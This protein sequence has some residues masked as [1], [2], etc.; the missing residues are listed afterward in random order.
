LESD[1]PFVAKIGALILGALI[2]FIKPLFV[3]VISYICNKYV[4][5]KQNHMRKL[6]AFLIGL[7]LM[8]FA[9]QSFASYEEPIK[10]DYGEQ[11]VFYI[12][13]IGYEPKAVAPED[14]PP[15]EHRQ[16]GYFIDKNDTPKPHFHG[17]ARKARDRLLCGFVG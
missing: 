8:A 2:F 11:P 9:I 5:P 15:S 7:L 3:F 12:A 13:C 14:A 1:T 10:K 16:K 4:S 6:I 17:S